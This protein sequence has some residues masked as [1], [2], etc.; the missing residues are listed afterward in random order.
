[1]VSNNPQAPLKK[2]S[3]KVRRNKTKCVRKYCTLQTV[4]ELFMSFFNSL[5]Q[6]DFIFVRL[7]SVTLTEFSCSRKVNKPKKYV[8]EKSPCFCF[9]QTFLMRQNNLFQRK[10]NIVWLNAK[11]WE[12]FP[13]WLS[14]I[15]HCHVEGK[16]E[17]TKSHF[18]REESKNYNLVGINLARVTDAKSTIKSRFG[19]ERRNCENIHLC[20]AGCSLLL[21]EEN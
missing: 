11:K 20:W 10:T 9:T 2:W 13:P 15:F 1:M 12:P 14:P 21:S 8:E 19:K 17:K 3:V 6:G 7:H 16:D 4:F 5:E 18:L